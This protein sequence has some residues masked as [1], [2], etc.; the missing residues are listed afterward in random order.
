ML[1]AKQAA[2]SYT[3]EREKRLQLLQTQLRQ[4]EQLHA[5]LPQLAPVRAKEVI[6]R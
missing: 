5:N 1:A 4:L 2:G 6:G 3:E